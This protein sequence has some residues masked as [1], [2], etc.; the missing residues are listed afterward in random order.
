MNHEGAVMTSLYTYHSLRPSNM[1]STSH[2]I[3]I[4]MI[5]SLA[6]THF[7]FDVTS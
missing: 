3:T 2:T 4:A 6:Q 7:V 5:G 1:Y